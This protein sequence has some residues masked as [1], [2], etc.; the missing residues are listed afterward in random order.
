[1]LAAELGASAIGLVF[2]PG[3][4]RFVEP[5]QA[6]AI[7]AALPPFVSAVGVFVDQ[8]AEYV[9]GSRGARAGSARCSFTATSRPDAYRACPA[10][11]HQGG[12]GDA[13]RST[14]LPWQPRCRRAP[15][16]CS[17]RTIR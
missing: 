6:R 2:W 5:E 3:S 13:I 1:M 11:R 17:M 4:P 15:P 9:R 16:C 14:R 7:V 12:R 10:P 8:P